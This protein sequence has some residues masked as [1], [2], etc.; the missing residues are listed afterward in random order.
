MRKQCPLKKSPKEEPVRIL[1]TFVLQKPELRGLSGSRL[2]PRGA[3]LD[4][5]SDGTPRTGPREH[6][7]NNAIVS[8]GSGVKK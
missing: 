7:Q 5:T 6:I 4:L 1:Q 3:G 2:K 8:H